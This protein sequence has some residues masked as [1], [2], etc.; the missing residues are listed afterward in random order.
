VRLQKPHR[1][2]HSYVQVLQGTPETVFPL[3]C[4]V[5]EQDWVPGWD[6][7]LVLSESGLA[8]QECLFVTP[9]EPADSIWI[10]SRHQPKD[11]FLEMYK[12][13]PGHTVGKLC[14]QL[15]ATG[16]ASCTAE[17]SYAYTALGP[18]GEQ[19]LESFT[20]AWYEEFMLGWQNALNHYLQTGKLIQE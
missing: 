15:T 19:F 13:S 14:I 9:S 10:I 1:I 5:R 17:V 12:V 8:E 18:A 7:E 6:P 3:L 2:Q 16:A 20:A 4:P 11:L